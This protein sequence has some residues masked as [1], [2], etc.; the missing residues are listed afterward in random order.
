MVGNILSKAGRS[1]PRRQRSIGH[2]MFAGLGLLA[3][4]CICGAAVL[5]FALQGKLGEDERGEA[6]QRTVLNVMNVVGVLCALVLG[7][8][9]AGAKANFDTRS[10]EVEQFAANLTL[11]DREL[12]HL[13]PGAKDSRDLLRAYTAR[14]IALTWPKHRRDAPVMHDSE[15]VAE[16]DEIQQKLRASTPQ[17]EVQREA[18]ANALQLIGESKRTSRLLAIQQSN[19]TPR[20]FYVALTF[21]LSALYLAHGV[22]APL[23]RTVVVAMLVGTFSV[24]VALNLIFDT[25]QP[26]AGFVRVSPTPMQQA[27]SQMSP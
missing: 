19:Q 5:G 13:E 22:F 9:I 12:M 1:I 3:F 10:G 6:S 15:T 11:L 7:L 2:P 17:T 24:S 8:L 20:P 16:L 21:W 25:E 23:N 14:K 27:L 18:R 26:F 4:F